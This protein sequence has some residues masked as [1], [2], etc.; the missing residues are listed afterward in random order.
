MEENITLLTWDISGTCFGAD[1]GQ[2]E[3][4]SRYRMGSRIGFLSIGMDV[5]IGSRP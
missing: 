4:A 2:R 3:H 5:S 1:Y